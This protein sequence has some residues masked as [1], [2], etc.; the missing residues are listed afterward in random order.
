VTRLVGLGLVMALVACGPRHGATVTV[1][2]P[3]RSSPS[4]TIGW[5]TREELQLE[6]KRLAG[7]LAGNQVAAAR[8]EL[9]WF[10]VQ[11]YNCEIKALVVPGAVEVLAR[12]PRGLAG[13]SRK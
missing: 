5:V 9:L 8:Q 11:H 3:P 1:S 12:C 13:D 2:A 4:P 6:A 10:E 7:L